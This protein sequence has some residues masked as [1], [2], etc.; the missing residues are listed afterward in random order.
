MAPII[1]PTIM[2]EARCSPAGARLFAWTGAALFAGSLAYFL[3]AYL[4]RYGAPAPTSGTAA[5]TAGAVLAN[6]AMFGVFALH[7][8]IAART[9]IKA[10]IM[11]VIPPVLERSAYTWTASLLFIA[12]CA[13]W[14][15]LPGE[16]YHL[17]GAAAL[18]GYLLQA[19]GVAMTLYSSARLDVLNLAGVRPLLNS[20]TPDDRRHGKH[21]KHVEHVPPVPSAPLETSGPYAFVR[22]PLYF[23][24][25]VLVFAAPHMTWTRAAFALIS[26]TYLAIAIPFEERSLIHTFGAEYRAYQQRV[27]WR[28]IPG[29]Y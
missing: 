6:V 25:V 22:H 29:L 20:G 2:L 15:F 27:R 9:S 16:L 21:G 10:R 14:Q 13:G 26:C 17:T 19:A 1:V 24:W 28:M 7:H 5:D 11:R 8:S 4:V 12:V 3:Y 18:P 23:A